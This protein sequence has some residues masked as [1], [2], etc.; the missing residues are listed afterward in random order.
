[1]TKT[2][3]LDIARSHIDAVI[4]SA[5]RHLLKVAVVVVD[6]GGHVVA[7]ARMDGVGY[8]NVEVA[9]RKA[10]AAQNFGAPTHD[11]AD[12]MQHDETIK[13]GL[14]AMSDEII[15]LP[16]GFPITDVV[17]VIGGL[18]IA[19][20]HYEQDRLVGQEAI[21]ELAAARYGASSEVTADA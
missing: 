4:R 7:S 20:G 8:L 17:T 16:G 3:T 5:E 15:L 10:N 12:F 2:I 6:R 11:V 9:R 1:M 19:G 13:T 18:G 14:M 21:A